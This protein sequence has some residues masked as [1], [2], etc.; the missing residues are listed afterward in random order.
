M[1]YLDR[2]C[3]TNRSPRCILHFS[4]STRRLTCSGQARWRL[5]AGRHWRVLSAESCHSTGASPGCEKTGCP[6]TL[7][8]FWSQFL[9]D[10]FWADFHLSDVSQLSR[11]QALQRAVEIPVGY[12]A[13]AEAKLD[14]HCRQSTKRRPIQGCELYLPWFPSIWQESFSKEWL[15]STA[16]HCSLNEK[17]C[18]SLWDVKRKVSFL[19]QIIPP[20]FR[21]TLVTCSTPCC[22][23]GSACAG[24]RT[25]ST[26][27]RAVSWERCG[28]SLTLG[29]RSIGTQT[30]KSHPDSCRRDSAA[31][32]LRTRPSQ[33]CRRILAACCVTSPRFPEK[34]CPSH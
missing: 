15:Q 13:G 4:H 21:K 29:A 31:E 28:C 16:K 23:Q 26:R 30:K 33:R 11:F 2:M 5:S 9:L 18:F 24:C 1:A 27:H 6:A 19:L 34:V 20:S 22:V 25:S 14:L 10:W 32:G 17:T 7:R 12:G 3:V 8:P